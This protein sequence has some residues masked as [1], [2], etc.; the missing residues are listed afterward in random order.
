MR[1]DRNFVWSAIQD[2]A[3]EKP[4]V[5]LSKCQKGYQWFANASRCLMVANDRKSQHQ[6]TFGQSAYQCSMDGAH[7]AS[8]E[9]CDEFE[10]FG[11]ELQDFYHFKQEMFWFGN[12]VPEKDTANK[13]ERN[14]HNK[15]TIN[16]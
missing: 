11:K 3:K 1:T 8:F 6:L 13:S 10:A 15:P 4:Y 9:S 5:C 16:S 12:I 7:L 2:K 14:F